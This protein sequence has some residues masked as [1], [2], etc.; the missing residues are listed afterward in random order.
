MVITIDGVQACVIQDAITQL[1]NSDN[2][3]P[4]EPVIVGPEHDADYG[5]C[6]FGGMEPA[7]VSRLKLEIERGEYAYQE[8]E[9]GPS[10]TATREL[11]AALP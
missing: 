11:L 7:D 9:D 8:T 5:T 6:D 2:P 10:V 3:L 4:V 1:K